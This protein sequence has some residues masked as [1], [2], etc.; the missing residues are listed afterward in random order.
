MIFLDEIFNE[1]KLKL[2]MYMYVCYK[3]DIVE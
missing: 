1:F 3:V 2:I